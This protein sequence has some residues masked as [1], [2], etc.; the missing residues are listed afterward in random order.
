MPR[1][2]HRDGSWGGRAFR[3]V[4]FASLP[5]LAQ[6]QWQTAPPT[7]LG[8]DSAKL[9]TLRA[10][11]AARGTRALI[12]AR[13]GRIALEW[14]AEGHHATRK[15]GTASLAK[16]LVGGLS[17]T[18]LVQDGIV[19][20]DD[21]A[22]RYIPAW[23]GDERKRRIT[24]RHLASH[25]SGLQDAEVE[26]LTHEQLTG[27]MG[28]FWR[29]DPNPFLTAIHDAPILFEPGTQFHYSNTG[30]AA[31]S[32]ALT[33][34]LR[35]AQAPQQNLRDLLRAR[36]TLPLGIPDEDWSIGYGQ[37][38]ET[39]GLPLYASWGGG[40]FTPRATARI[41]QLLADGGRI[42]ERVLIRPARLA[43]MKIANPNALPARSPTNPVPAPAM[44]WYTNEDR[45]WPSIPA[46]AF[47]GAGAGHQS[48]LVIPSLDLVV[49]RNGTAL[50]GAQRR[51]DFWGPM[52]EHLYAPTV[53]AVLPHGAHAPYPASTQITGVEWAP[54]GEIRI[55]AQDSDNWPITWMDDGFQFTSYGDGKGFA[56]FVDRKLSLGWARLTGGPLDFTA[57][58]VRTT[59]GERLGDGPAGAKVSG[60]LMVDGALYAFARNTGNAQLLYSHDRGLTWTWAWK[61]TTAFGSPSFL[62]FGPHYQG[63][64]D[65]FVYVYS[66]SGPSAYFSDD[67]LLLARAPRRR[68]ADPSAWHYFAGMDGAAPRWS[69]RIEDRREVWSFP[70]HAQ[71]VDAVYHPTLR[72]YLLLIGYDH[73]GGWGIYDAPTPWGPWTTAFHT[74]D[75][76]LGDTHGYRLPT[77]WINGNDAWLVFSG[78][79]RTRPNYD[80][81]CVRRLRLLTPNR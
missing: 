49:V 11:L 77:A 35:E 15:Q 33:A 21:P 31:L 51:A 59:T 6:T 46:D 70:A 55:A 22:S 75:W 1:A 14:Y 53:A 63:A 72:R 8:L 52:L 29:R 57:T 73:S 54:P 61:W 36:I 79:N 32:Y 43:E 5:A 42:G 65:E 39:G 20:W 50:N 66:Q 62:Q 24:L 41:G 34:A 30:M 13:R 56:P 74:H 4:L 68:I 12:V 9:E 60:L 7:A 27:W 69:P 67:G 23:R 44:G 80:A 18:L 64:P 17:L 78:S 37:A 45:I 28:A 40:S 16:S 19:K 3:L 25:T 47:C 81:F 38:Y 71:R 10:H 58:N 2:S 48:L 76:G 26:G